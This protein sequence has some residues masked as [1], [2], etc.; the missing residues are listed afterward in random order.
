M[1]G[2]AC[3]ECGVEQDFETRV[4][5]KGKMCDTY[6]THSEGTVVL[7]RYWPS[8]IY[9]LGEKIWKWR[10]FAPVH[11]YS[12]SNSNSCW[13]LLG[14]YYVPSTV[15]NLLHILTHLIFT[16]PY[17]VGTIATHIPSMGEMSHRE[18]NLCSQIHR[19]DKWQRRSSNPARVAPEPGLWTTTSPYSPVDAE[20]RARCIDL[21]LF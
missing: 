5:L 20:L 14:T 10:L 1:P 8:L 19:A 7:G 13:H 12:F 6:H 16:A 18:A 3:L 4:F 17:K 2:K 9:L 15:P 21:F 11:Y